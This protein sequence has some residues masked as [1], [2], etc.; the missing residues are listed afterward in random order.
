[1]GLN[2]RIN[3]RQLV[4]IALFLWVTSVCV[5]A[6][7]PPPPNPAQTDATRPPGTQT[8]TT[9]PPNARPTTIDPSAPPGVQTS[10]R[11]QVTPIPDRPTPYVPPTSDMSPTVPDST[12]QT[13]LP[14]PNL[15]QLPARP[16]PPLPDLS[17]LGVNS[18]DTIPMSLNDAIRRALENN[19]DIEVSR[20]D[21]RI[22]EA[23][24][25]ALEGV[26]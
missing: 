10:P 20:Q 9:I 4:I 19:N 23:G 18:A 17:R 1:M 15:P 16:V 13:G 24:L 14:V 3:T 2:I 22:A 8:N 25:R 21:V 6:Q 7:N 11:P 12:G 26:Y 5:E